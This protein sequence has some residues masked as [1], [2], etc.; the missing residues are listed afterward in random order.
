MT[1]LDLLKNVENIDLGSAVSELE[2]YRFSPEP[3]SSLPLLHIGY[4][5][6]FLVFETWDWGYSTI[7]LWDYSGKKK[8]TTK[9]QQNFTI[10][11]MSHDV[12]KTFIVI[13]VVLIVIIAK[14]CRF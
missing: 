11:Y 5:C 3:N 1:K 6:C 12:C 13:S 8:T 10:L 2:Y 9:K 7:S 4:T 14:N